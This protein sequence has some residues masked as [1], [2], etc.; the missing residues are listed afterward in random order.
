MVYKRPPYPPDAVGF[1]ADDAAFLRR[2]G[3]NTVRLG[4]IYK[5]VEPQPGHYDGDLHRHDRAR[6][7]GCSPATGIFSLLDFHQ[8]LY[9]EKFGGEGLPDW[10][11]LDDGLPAEPLPASRSPTSPA[12][13][14]TGPSTTCGRTTPGRAASP[15]QDRY[16]A[17]WA[18]VARGFKDDRGRAGLRPPQRAVAGHRLRHAVAT[19]P[20]APPS[21]AASLAPF[22]R[23]VISAHPRRRPPPP[24]LLRAASA[25]Q[26]RRRHEP[27]KTRLR[28]GLGFSFHDYC[29]P[30]LVGGGADRLRRDRAAV[31][32]NADAASRSRPA[33]RCCSPSTGRPTTSPPSSAS[34]SSPT[35]TWSPGRSGT[36]AG[37][38]TQPPAAPETSRLWSRIRQAASG[39]ERLSRQAQG[40]RPPLPTGDRGHPDEVLLSTP[41]PA[42]SSSS[43][44]RSGRTAMGASAAG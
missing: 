16:A 7:S 14:S 43:T 5:A 25:V 37:A 9:N 8:D 11:V 13:A 44:R 30:G 15:I 10:A 36:T 28:R 12:R 3:F 4:L 32:D 21:T 33:T 17:A 42:A 2:N 38:A 19:P 31:F 20:A 34:P 24:C 1:G 29:L 6:P 39:I 18:R 41:P 27:P 22:Y 26:L 40:A 23:R 35:V